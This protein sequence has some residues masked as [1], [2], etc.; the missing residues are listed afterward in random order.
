MKKSLKTKFTLGLLCVSIIPVLI[1]FYLHIKSFYKFYDERT[2]IIA[3]GEMEKAV[4]QIDS[5]FQEVD[6]LV[7]SLIHSRYD[8]KYCIQ[9]IAGME[10]AD[11]D[12]TAMQRLT[13][14]REFIYICS[15]LICNNKYVEGVYLFTESGYTYSYTKTKEFYLEKDY[16]ESS[17]Y[18]QM[19]DE[20]LYQLVTFW[21]SPSKRVTEKNILEVRPVADERGRKTGYIAVVCNNNMMEEID[22][23]SALD[24]EAVILDGGGGF[25]YRIMGDMDLTAAEKER[26]RNEDKGIIGIK[27]GGII[28][29]TL[30]LNNWKIVSRYGVDELSELYQK[31]IMNL[32]MLL[33]ICVG[34]IIA[35]VFVIGRHFI[36]PIVKL[37][38]MML[39]V[40]DEEPVLSPALQKRDDEIGILYNKFQLMVIKINE[41]IQEQYVSQINLLREKLNGLM[42]QINSHFLFNT[43][44]NINCLA[45]LDGNRK[46]AMMSK[47]LGD[48]LHYSMEFERTEETLEAEMENI[49]KYVEIQEIRFDNKI[50][51]IEEIPDELRTSRVLKFMLQPLVENSIEHGLIGE[52]DVWWIRIQAWAEQKKLCIRVENAGM[53]ITP[54]ELEEIRGNITRDKIREAAEAEEL[55]RRRN[56]IGLVNI[57]RRIKLVYSD[58]YGLEIYNRESGGLEVLIRLPLQ[59][60]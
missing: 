1:L 48:M 27:D 54:E 45:D 50:H 36:E 24:N 46:I 38:A 17:W 55:K 43:L 9:S 32:V 6:E 41:L 5:A 59:T 14:Y 30:S 13:N 47:S 42:S 18:R 53:Y 4:Y 25:L 15:N 22:S 35:S 11:T 8:N 39:K 21:D 10:Y 29:H 28:F 26:I 34:F 19:C 51:V 40:P 3:S 23:D 58:R 31:N 60:E 12:I 57:Q 7:A 33:L 16:Q 2:S 49:R 44:E 20:N 52:E 56:S 37:S